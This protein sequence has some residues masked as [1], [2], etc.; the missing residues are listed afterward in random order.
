MHPKQT[1]SV[2]VAALSGLNVDYVG[3]CQ[4]PQRLMASFSLLSTLPPGQGAG[5]K[6]G[7]EF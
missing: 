6:T 1:C 4:F 5:F 7:Q 2:T 3:L